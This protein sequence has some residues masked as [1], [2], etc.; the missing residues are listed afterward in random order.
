MKKE[1][2]KGNETSTYLRR[3]KRSHNRSISALVHRN[4][5]KTIDQRNVKIN[6][7]SD[8]SYR[9]AV[10]VLQSKGMVFHTYENKQTRPF[11]VMAKGLD[12]S[13]DPN[14]IVT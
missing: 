9:K 6:L 8:D 1:T 7:E 12:S 11:R 13:S 4:R 14:E 3:E 5:T 10:N 2:K